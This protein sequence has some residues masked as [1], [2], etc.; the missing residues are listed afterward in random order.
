MQKVFLFT[1]NKTAHTTITFDQI[2]II[3]KYLLFYLQ[4]QKCQ[5]SDP[6]GYIKHKVADTVAQVRMRSEERR[7]GKAG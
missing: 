2:Q 4:T 3:I 7:V 1:Q 5:I 6:L